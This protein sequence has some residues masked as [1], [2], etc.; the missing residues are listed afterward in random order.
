M[1]AQHFAPAVAQHEAFRALP[2]DWPGA[3]G[4]E[5]VYFVRRA[6]VAR[7]NCPAAEPVIL[8]DASLAHRYVGL[9]L[10]Q[11]V[12][13]PRDDAATLRDARPVFVIDHR[14]AVLYEG[15]RPA[16]IVVDHRHT[17]DQPSSH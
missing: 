5:R 9:R 14:E 15:A 11:V 7:G 4:A 3:S 10:L 17:D 16:A 1:V 13:G 2:C 6:V 12:D 8:V